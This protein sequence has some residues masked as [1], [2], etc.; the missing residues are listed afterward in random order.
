MKRNFEM[1]VGLLLYFSILLCAVGL[2][3]SALLPLLPFTRA[4][5][6]GLFANSVAYLAEGGVAVTGIVS[7]LVCHR[8]G[9]NLGKY[10][11]CKLNWVEAVLY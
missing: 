5:A 10:Q 11:L 7:W 4:E 9:R 3:G 6:C 8:S 1:V 2:I